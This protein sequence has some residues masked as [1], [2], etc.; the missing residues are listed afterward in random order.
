MLTRHH[1]LLV[2]LLVLLGLDKQDVPLQLVGVP[3]RRAQDPSAPETENSLA[4]AGTV[5]VTA[6]VADAHVQIS[7]PN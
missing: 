3:R 5:V 1:R 7:E 6:R 2:D 4:D